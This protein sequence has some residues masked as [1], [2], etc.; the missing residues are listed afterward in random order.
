MNFFTKLYEPRK[1]ASLDDLRCIVKGVLEDE[2]RSRKLLE[3]KGDDAQL[4]LDALQVLGELPDVPSKLR[5]SI[6]KMM[7]RLAKRSGLC[8]QCLMIKNV[9]RLGDFPVGGGGFGDVWKGKI[10]EQTVCL[11]VVKVY[12]VSDVR[13]LL[14]EYMREA[15]VWRQ[16]KHPNLLPFMGMYYLDKTREQL[17]LV[18]PWME[19]GNLVRYLKDTPREQ[20]D[21]YSLVYDVA[22][23]LSYLHRMKIVHGDLKGVNILVTPDERACIGD[24]GLS[25][26]ADTHALRLTSSTATHSKGTTRWLSPEILS[27]DPPCTSSTFSDIYAFACV[28]YEIF[29]G[30]VPFHELVDGAVIVAVLIHKKYPPR[31]NLTSVNDRIWKI[32]VDCWDS[33]PQLRPAASEVLT[34]VAGFVSLKTGGSINSAS[35]WDTFNL[36]QIWKNVK[37]PLL[38]TSALIRLQSNL[39]RFP[40]IAQPTA[41]P[42]QETLK[43]TVEVE[44]DHV[45]EVWA[46]ACMKLEAELEAAQMIIEGMDEARRQAEINLTLMDLQ[47]RVEDWRGFPLETFGQLLLHD[48]LIVMSSNLMKE[49]RVFLFEK[50]LFLCTDH[51]PIPIRVRSPLNVDATTSISWKNRSPIV[52]NGR[53][54]I[55]AVDRAEVI[56]TTPAQCVLGIWWINDGKTELFTLQFDREDQMR[57]W[58]ST[59]NRLICPDT[60]AESQIS[61][62]F[63][64]STASSQLLDT[65]D[66]LNDGG[67]KRPLSAIVDSGTSRRFSFDVKGAVRRYTSP[68]FNRSASASYDHLPR[69]HMLGRDAHFR[70]LSRTTSNLT[71]AGKRASLR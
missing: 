60:D 4:W 59:L 45:R 3:T 64:Y 38:D 63:P 23:G 54:A 10:G 16:L 66:M 24:F 40:A 11:K 68:L 41:L 30:N 50:V 58:V 19:R 34:R 55:A 33:N 8:P 62:H 42:S 69:P 46:M 20:V 35:D 31:P 37:Y 9:K 21:H 56:S 65:E 12:L 36:S 2:Q 15:I 18:S 48:T 53:I 61:P 43:P 5:S 27:S 22:S 6:L 47:S 51:N 32:M 39:G 67:W 13:Q 57:E 1:P 52:V 7:L 71:R 14:T 49:C 28:C 26:V 17:C 70:R 29:T 44:R 25:R